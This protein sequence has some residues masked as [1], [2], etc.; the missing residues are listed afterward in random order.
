MLYAILAEKESWYIDCYTYFWCHWH[1]VVLKIKL[2][3]TAA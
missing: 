2:Y 1:T 3:T